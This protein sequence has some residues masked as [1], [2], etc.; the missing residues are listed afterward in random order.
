[1]GGGGKGGR[2]IE[3]QVADLS[4]E[5]DLEKGGKKKRLCL[6]SAVS[7][8]GCL[9]IREEENRGGKQLVKPSPGVRWRRG[10]VG[11]GGRRFERGVDGEEALPV[12][13]SSEKGGGLG[14]NVLLEAKEEQGKIRASREGLEFL[15]KRG[16]ETDG[17]KGFR[18]TTAEGGAGGKKTIKRRNYGRDFKGREMAT[19][20]ASFQKGIC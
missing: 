6:M 2:K 9:S 11:G 8:K 17:L 1:M 14:N 12:G 13:R 4:S 18:S 20:E 19:V 5:E 7:W 15:E 10:G 3:K 16:N